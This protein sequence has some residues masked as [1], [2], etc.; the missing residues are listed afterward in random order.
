MKVDIATADLYTDFD[1]KRYYFC[2]QYCKDT[3]ETDPEKY[4]EAGSIGKEEV[5]SE[6]AV[7]PIC[8]MDVNTST[9]TLMSE[10]NGKL[11]YFC[12]QHC[13]ETFDANPEE[14]KNKDFRES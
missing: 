12:S 2:A 9:A 13:K 6:V 1:G 10:Y 3:F 14:Y 11:Y 7:D 4:R 5:I 8:K